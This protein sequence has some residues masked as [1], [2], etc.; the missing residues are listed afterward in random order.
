VFDL[1]RKL[2]PE[3]CQLLQKEVRYHGHILSPKGISTN[4]EKL[5]IVREWP[6]SKNKH[7]IRRFMGLCT[8]YRQFISC[9]RIAIDV[10]GPFP[11]SDQGSRYLLIAVDYF[12]KG[13]EAYAIPNLEASRLAEALVNNFFNFGIPQELHSYQGCNF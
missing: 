4:P 3:K 7:D 8:Y 9:L 5:K 12:T 10:A 11:R 1:F 13:P 6:T 2:N